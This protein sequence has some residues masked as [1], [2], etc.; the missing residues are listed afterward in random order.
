MRSKIGAFSSTESVRVKIVWQEA[1]TSYMVGVEPHV[2]PRITIRR[3][4]N[5]ARLR[6]A[7]DVLQFL[8][9]LQRG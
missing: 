7:Q 1:A 2:M 8:K 6:V 9:K 3:P 5:E 4:P